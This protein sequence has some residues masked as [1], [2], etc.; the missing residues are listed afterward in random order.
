M[1]L[2]KLSLHGFKAFASPQEFDFTSGTTAIIGPNGSGKSNVADAIRWVFGEQSNK[3]IRAKKTEDVIFMGSDSRRSMGIAEVTVVLDNEDK[4]I[5]LDFAEVSITRRA[6]RS[7]DNEY[8]INENKVRHSDVLALMSQAN[9]SQNSYAFVSQGLAD[10]IIELKPLDRRI[11]IEEAANIDQFRKDLVLTKRRIDETRDNIL[12]VDLILK[13]LKPRV[14]FY[15]RFQK[16]TAKLK[17]LDKHINILLY[18]FYDAKLKSLHE[19]KNSLN[20]SLI[21]NNKAISSNRAML[22]SS[23]KTLSSFELELSNLSSIMSANQSE[24]DQL[25]NQINK[26]DKDLAISNQKNSDLKRQN[27]SL[28]DDLDNLTKLQSPTKPTEGKADTST[29][30]EQLKQ[31]ANEKGELIDSIAINDDCIKELIQKRNVSQINLDKEFD[32][33]DTAKEQLFNCEK[34]IREIELELSL[35]DQY[36]KEAPV[37]NDNVNDLL[38]Q[39]VNDPSVNTK[40]NIFGPLTRLI[41]VPDKYEQAIEA[42]LVGF[43]NSIVVSNAND[44]ELCFEYLKNHDFGSAKLLLLDRAPQS[45]PLTIMR[46][47]GVVGIASK[48]VSVDEKYQKLVDALL[49]KTIIVEDLDIA[50]VILSRGIG[51]VVTLDGTLLVNDFT[52][53]GGSAQSSGK[54]FSIQSRIDDLKAA[55]SKE[56]QKIPQLKTDVVKADKVIDQLRKIITNTEHEM[57]KYDHERKSLN[58]SLN[59]TNDNISS[60]K[61]SL[62]IIENGGSISIINNSETTNKLIREKT[63]ELTTIESDLNENELIIRKLIQDAEILKN[64]KKTFLAKHQELTNSSLEYEKKISSSKL[65]INDT[66]KQIQ[67]LEN[68][69]FQANTKQEQNIFELNNILEKIEQDSFS[70]NDDGA[71][72]QQFSHLDEDIKIIMNKYREKCSIDS[73]SSLSASNLD[74]LNTITNDMRL[75]I[76][77]LGSLDQEIEADLISDK[78]RYDQLVEQTGDLIGSE[79]ELQSVIKKLEFSISEKFSETF[80]MVNEKFNHYFREVFDG[81]NA[82]LKMISAENKSEQG[83][84]IIVKP[85]GKR[86][87]NLAAL[88]GGERAMTSVALMFALMSVNPSP[89]C[90]LDEIDAALDDANVKRFLR[91]LNELSQNSQF[92]VITHNRITVQDA[93][94]VYGISMEQDATS[95]VLSLKIKDLVN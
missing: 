19:Q 77:K 33:Y 88:S 68:S 64:N 10:R 73:W 92:I 44:A 61:T 87:S 28:K 72:N 21:N 16:K 76:L 32:S 25:N 1:Y 52:Y 47:T 23:A 56:T 3:N 45:P 82:E 31:L 42:S 11:L 13:E 6:H 17:E 39:F 71:I 50:K 57:S 94:T 49:G 51:Q 34:I 89:I 86:L 24:I 14:N 35:L 54:H 60:T 37:N 12:K 4:W 65:S 70:I 40:P 67:T 58:N 27:E 62:G 41:Q 29:V 80:Q 2:R 8:F 18:Y 9:M 48:L 53:Y 83:I 5:P 22:D 95:T 30:N 79:E 59:K 43:L 46:E 84:E 26:I 91:I 7:G 78:N 74:S 90:V 55:L 63:N 75:Q 81:G 66:E 69:N 38:N 85:P 15:E 93:E 20:D 36:Y